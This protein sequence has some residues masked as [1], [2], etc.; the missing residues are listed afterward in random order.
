MIITIIIR[1]VLECIERVLHPAQPRVLTPSW[2]RQFLRPN[3]NICY[4][5]T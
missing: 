5:L 3:I 1:Q 2:L 4:L